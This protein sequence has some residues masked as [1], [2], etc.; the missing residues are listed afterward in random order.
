MDSGIFDPEFI[1]VIVPVYNSQASLPDLAARLKPVLDSLQARWEVIL[2]NDASRDDSWSVIR[3]LTAQDSRL[4]GIDLMR[5]YGQH[6]ALLCGIREARGDV[7]VTMDDDL[8]HP[9]E[10]LPK[11]LDRLREGFDVVYGT[12][13][14]QQHGLLRDVASYLTKFALQNM[15]GAE[16][17]RNVSAFRA[18]RTPVRQAFAQYSSPYVSLDALLTW[19]TAKFSAVRVRHDPRRYGTSNYTVAKL[20]TVAVNLSTGFTTAPLR[21]ASLVGFAFTL[22][23]FSVLA[24]VLVQYF[25]HPG[26]VPGFPFLASLAAIFAG[27]QLFALGVI[28]EYL[29]RIHLRTMDRPAYSVRSRTKDGQEAIG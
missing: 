14:S 20:V 11:L 25:R 1:S 7:I 26:A 13:E 19:G 9:P 2:V 22:F 16:N 15:M 29:A 5:N 24:F 23:G 6:N 8:Q 3:G 27:A 21:F 12:P 18:F 17:A 4:R 10:E 28:G